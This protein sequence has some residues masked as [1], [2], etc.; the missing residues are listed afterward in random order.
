RL[1]A[2]VR[3]RAQGRRFVSAARAIH[4]LEALGLEL[5]VPLVRLAARDEPAEQ[6][7]QLARSIG[8]PLL[9]AAVFLG[10]LSQVASRLQTSIGTGPGP[11]QV[12]AA[13]RTLY[14]EHRAERERER[15][16]ESRMAERRAAARASGEVFVERRYAG[17]PTYLDQIATSLAT[18][19]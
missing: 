19:F 14:A 9:A 4:W 13:A 17:K 5:F 11:A 8:A 3:D 10:L 12:V 15:E 2:H 16:F 1:S 7:R 18:V 6:V